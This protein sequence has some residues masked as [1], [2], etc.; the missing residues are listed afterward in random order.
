MV[1]YEYHDIYFLSV[2]RALMLWDFCVDKCDWLS[3][4]KMAESD[5]DEEDFITFGTGLPTFEDGK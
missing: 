1:W 5:T 2:K 4:G 3:I